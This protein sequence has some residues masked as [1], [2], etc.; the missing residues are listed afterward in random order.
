VHHDLWDFDLPTPL[1]LF[2]Q[3]Y[4]GEMR[5][6]LAAHSKQG[7]VYILDRVTG[8]P[9]LPIE[10]KPFPQDAR[11]KTAATQP[12]PAGDPTA[13]QCAEPVATYERGCMFTSFW[14]DSRIAQPSASGDWAPG[15]YD[16]ASGYLFFTVG[17]STRKFSPTGRVSVPGTREYGLITAL[18]SRTNRQVWQAE[19]PYLAG[20]GSGVLATAG[21]LLGLL[22]VGDVAQGGEPRRLARPVQ[23][24]HPHLA[25]AAALEVELHRLAGA[26]GEAEVVA[27]H[28]LAGLAEQALGGGVGELHRAVPVDDQHGVRHR[29]DDAAEAVVH[30]AVGTLLGAFGFGPLG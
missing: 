20:F 28:L 9:I 23:L 12:V 3:V 11:Q 25:H 19:V 29:V 4:N 2:D 30:A 17:V 1:I 10:E 8:K 18:D 15:A 26:H 24:H 13:P 22:A 14:S 5:K 16:P 21:G 7:W 6:A 27:H